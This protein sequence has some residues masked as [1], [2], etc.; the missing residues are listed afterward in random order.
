MAGMEAVPGLASAWLL[1]QTATPA[2]VVPA[3]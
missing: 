2:R 1:R 3:P